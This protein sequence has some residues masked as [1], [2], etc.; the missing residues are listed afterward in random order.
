MSALLHSHIPIV[1]DAIVTPAEYI[2]YTPWG[3]ILG[4]VLIV[5]AVLLTVIL[6]RRFF[7]NKKK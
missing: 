1:L 5:A 6:V 7:G 4:G 2:V 3:N